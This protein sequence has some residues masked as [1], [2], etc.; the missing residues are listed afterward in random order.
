M[1]SLHMSKTVKM[2]IFLWM[3]GIIISII[4]WNIYGVRIMYDSLE[5]EESARLLQ[6]GQLNDMHRMFYMGYIALLAI[7]KSR[8]FIVIIQLIISLVSASVLFLTL[9][10]YVVSPFI[11]IVPSL[12]IMIWPKVFIWHYFILTES[13]FISFC[14]L[15]LCAILW[16]RP[17]NWKVFLI[18]L[19][20]TS[21]RPSGLIV[22]FSYFI[23]LISFLINKYQLSSLKRQ[24]VVAFTIVII[25]F[26]GNMALKSFNI[27]ETWGSGKIVYNVQNYPDKMIQEDLT[28]SNRDITIPADSKNPMI[29]MLNFTLLNPM[30]SF[31]LFVIKVLYFVAD[32]RPYYSRIHIGINAILL[33]TCYLLSIMALRKY[34]F[35]SYQKVFLISIVIGFVL[36]A[37]ITVLSWEGRFFAPIYPILFF[38]SAIGMDILFSGK[39]IT[40]LKIK[41]FRSQASSS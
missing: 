7:L 29:E 20:T 22:L 40:H 1:N 3:A 21:I 19:L 11:E 6:D 34:P 15:S 24:L 39:S 26:L 37:G 4:G 13:L 14:C 18:V 23:C 36:M 17:T 27:V 9:K 2:M 35:K 8:T 25:L 10:K 32:I 30:F 33:S 5:Y 38:L 31:K 12:L 28:L 41:L 16:W